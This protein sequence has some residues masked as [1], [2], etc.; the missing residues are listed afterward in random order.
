MKKITYI[1]QIYP[2]TPDDRAGWFNHSICKAYKKLGYKVNVLMP[3]TVTSG[4]ME[5]HLWEL[6][7]IKVTSL[8]FESYDY[9]KM[10]KTKV[11]IRKVDSTMYPQTSLLELV[12]LLNEN[13][14]KYTI[15]IVGSEIDDY[16]RIETQ[17]NLK[18]RVYH[19]LFKLRKNI[20]AYKLAHAAGNR[21]MFISN[22]IRGVFVVKTKINQGPVLPI[23]LDLEHLEP[24]T[25]GFNNRKNLLA[26]KDFRGKKYQVGLMIRT[27]I[28]L[29]PEYHLT[30]YGRGR[31]LSEYQRMARG[32]N[33][34]LPG[35]DITREKMNKIFSTAGIYFTPT[36]HE[37]QG[38][39]AMEAS[40]LGL[41]VVSTDNTAVPQFIKHNYNGLLAYDNS[42]PKIYAQLIEKLQDQRFYNRIAKYGPKMMSKYDTVGQARKELEYVK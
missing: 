7:G 14:V 30:I 35:Q 25:Q 37:G 19:D 29:G 4:M 10:R 21:F 11:I 38:L 31:Y 15:G 16:T 17:I 22:Y 24:V 32:H 41:P 20:I 12:R 28:L 8:P 27:A 33:I 2:K 3:C 34:S 6:E 5:T 23:G 1:T 18:E 42:G 40:A 26:F 13:R 36:K 9:K 39:A